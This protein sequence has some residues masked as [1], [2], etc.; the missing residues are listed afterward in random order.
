[1]YRSRAQ[2]SQIRERRW[3]LRDDLGKVLFPVAHASLHRIAD[4]IRLHPHCDVRTD[5][6]WMPSGREL[7]GQMVIRWDR[8]IDGQAYGCQHV[9]TVWELEEAHESDYYEMRMAD[10]FLACI[11]EVL[12]E[13]PEHIPFA[14]SPY[15]APFRAIPDDYQPPSLGANKTVDGVRLIPGQA[16][17]RSVE[18]AGRDGIYRV[19]A[20]KWNDID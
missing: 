16:F 20:G 13:E 1:M 9:V 2:I 18:P 14:I 15:A 5:W 6:Q 7:N 3:K 17:G 12:P 10:E 8:E 4:L 19:S 11:R